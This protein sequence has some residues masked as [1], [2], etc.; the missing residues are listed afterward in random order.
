MGHRTVPGFS[1]GAVVADEA[2]LPLLGADG[3]FHFA[4]SE[5]TLHYWKSGAWNTFASGGG[6]GASWGSITGTLSS[7]LDL[8]AALNAKAPLTS[9]TFVTSARFG[10]ATATTV[11]YL[12]SNKD[13]ISSSVTPTELGL[14]SGKTSLI[15]GAGTVIDNDIPVFT[16]TTGAAIKKFSGFS[17]YTGYGAGNPYLNITTGWGVRT[18][19]SDSIEVTSAGHLYLSKSAANLYFLNGNGDI[20]NTSFTLSPDNAYIG[21][22]V[23]LSGN[24]GVGNWASATTLGTVNGK[25]EIRDSAGTS[26][27]YLPTYDAIT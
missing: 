3:D 12:D 5:A 19:S 18:N 20:G 25:V 16:G 6:G 11:P 8:I 17:L 26:K 15:P 14:L 1:W 7:Q 24:L 21:G 13:L 10:Y 2:S 4:L 27:G 23:R 22:N 9:P